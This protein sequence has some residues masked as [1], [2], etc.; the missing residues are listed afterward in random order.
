MRVL[1]SLV[2]TLV[3]TAFPLPLAEQDFRRPDSPPL[4][5][6]L[7]PIVYAGPAKINREEAEDDA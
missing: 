4:F 1:G 7:D 2:S 3:D 5:R 6:F